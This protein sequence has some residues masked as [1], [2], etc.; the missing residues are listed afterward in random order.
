MSRNNTVLSTVGH[1]S[2]LKGESARHFIERLE[3]GFDTDNVKD[4]KFNVSLRNI[5]TLYH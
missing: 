2:G 5:V 3:R 1:F 4:D